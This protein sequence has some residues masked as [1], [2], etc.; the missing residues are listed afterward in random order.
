[1]STSPL[2][3]DRCLVGGSGLGVVVPFDGHLEELRN[4][5]G[6]QNCGAERE[7]PDR[8]SK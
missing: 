6:A 5:D 1:V 4:D 3:R 8:P 2:G 7:V